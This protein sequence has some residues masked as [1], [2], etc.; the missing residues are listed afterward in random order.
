MMPRQQSMLANKQHSLQSA[1]C[2]I[3]DANYLPAGQP[4]VNGQLFY[5]QSDMRL[6]FTGSGEFLAFPLQ[7]VLE[8]DLLARSVGSGSSISSTSLA[9]AAAA[10]VVGS[11]S[12]SSMSSASSTTNSGAAGNLQARVG[13]SVRLK[14]SQS[15]FAFDVPGGRCAEQAAQLTA[16]IASERKRLLPG[17][18]QQLLDNFPT[19]APTQGPSP[20]GL[21][22]KFSL[23]AEFIRQGAVNNPNW[24]LWTANED[25]AV[26]DTYPRLLYVPAVVP[27]Q[28]LL[29]CAKFR[30]RGRLPVLTYLYE[31]RQSALCRCSQPL[32]GLNARS[33]S[34]EHVVQAISDANP[35]ANAK[36][37]YIVDTRP[38]ANAI[39]NRAMG[40]GYELAD[41]YKNVEVKFCQIENIHVMRDSQRH[42]AQ[43]CQEGDSSGV[44]A[45]AWTSRLNKSGWPKHLQ[46]I[47]LAAQ[48]IA[49]KLLIEGA[50]VLVHCSDGW[51][52]TAQTAALAQ[53]LID[54]HY[55]T[56]HGFQDLVEKE[57]LSFGHKFADRCAHYGWSDESSPVFTQFLDCVHQLRRLFPSRFEFNDAYLLE[58]AEAA[59]SCHRYGTFLGNCERERLKVAGELADKWPAMPC[60]WTRALER[61]SQFIDPMYCREFDTRDAEPAAYLRLGA[62]PRCLIKPWLA[63]QNPWRRRPAWLRAAPPDS[64]QSQ[65]ESLIVL[66]VD[67]QQQPAAASPASATVLAVNELDDEASLMRRLAQSAERI[68]C[69]EDH[70]R[71]LKLQQ[72]QSAA[73]RSNSAGSQDQQDPDSRRLLQ[74]CTD[75]WEFETPAN[76]YACGVCLS[77]C[78]YAVAHRANCLACGRLACSLCLRLLLPDNI[79]AADAIDGDVQLSQRQLPP[80][81][82]GQT[83]GQSA[84]VCRICWPETDGLAQVADDAASLDADHVT[85]AIEAVQIDLMS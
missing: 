59:Y 52:R 48:F 29:E 78:G 1:A 74:L 25:Y 53:L 82:I 34:D 10:A 58:L 46:A 22:Y 31:T 9:S 70:E 18:L 40:K 43:A 41:N 33:S 54:P 64:D 65:P 17:S 13:L 63:L 32:V 47:L 12:P 73:E 44:T 30:S 21:L 51:D 61:R 56:L 3:E 28:V 24:R 15:V 42:L 50:S 7:L 79:P 84:M 69:L 35:N 85:A 6:V 38:M 77:P 66:D 20:S 68:A 4:P 45:H 11:P 81:L 55:R 49:D 80:L 5:N 72:R 67:E 37:L 16:L 39:G 26:C 36:R 23:E 75:A 57:W 19:Q 60:F 62:M 83:R 8:V 76:R 27:D 14:L 71:W 2:L